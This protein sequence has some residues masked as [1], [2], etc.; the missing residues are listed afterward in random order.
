MDYGAKIIEL[1][2][3]FEDVKMTHDLVTA[4]FGDYDDKMLRFRQLVADKMLALHKGEYFVTDVGRQYYM[5]CVAKPLSGEASKLIRF[6]D[7]VLTGI[8]ERFSNKSGYKVTEPSKIVNAVLP[9]NKRPGY[10][11]K[12]NI[13]IGRTINKEAR[14]KIMRDLALSEERYE[15]YMAE[16]RIRICNKGTRHIGI[17]DKRGAGW[18]SH[19]R[20]CRKKASKK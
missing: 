5:E 18:Q 15:E 11:G 7:E 16:G 10:S 8:I 12:T 6:R 1:L 17:F 9:R 13:R 4:L 19:C 2:L 20:E 14:H 3:Q